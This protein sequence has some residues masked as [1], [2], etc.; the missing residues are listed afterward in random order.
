MKTD[1]ASNNTNSKS[2]EHHPKENDAID[3][4]V[5]KQHTSQK[6][7]SKNGSNDLVDLCGPTDYVSAGDKAAMRKTARN[8]FELDYWKAS[9]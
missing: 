5:P 8:G 4:T 2:Q 1:P 3:L 7:T 9:K 6:I